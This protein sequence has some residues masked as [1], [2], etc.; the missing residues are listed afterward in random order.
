MPP[1]RGK[2]GPE[3]DCLTRAKICELHATNGWGATTI[4]KL[5]FPDI[6][7][8][9][10]QYTLTQESKRIK[11]ESLSRIGRPRKLTDEDRDHIY[12]TIQQNP[13]ILVEDLLAEV[14][15]KVKRMAIWRLT[16]EMGL[17]KWRKMQR[18]SLTPLHAEK[19]LNWAQKYQHFTSIDWARVYWSDECTV[20]RGIGQRQEWTFTRPKDQLFQHSEEGHQVQMVPARGKQIKQMFWAA[21]CGLPRRSGLIPLF[22]DPLSRRG[23]VSS[24]TIEELYRRVLP[25]LL[26]SINQNAIFQQDNAL[27]H[28]AYIVR[29]ALNELEC[30]IMEWPPYSPDLNPIENL[31]ALLKAEI[32]KGYPE[33][34]HL[35]NN[36]STLELLVKAAQEAWDT[37]DT[38]IFKHLSETMPHRV[39]DVIKYEGWHT[40]Y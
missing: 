36:A 24:R 21:F 17:R 9:T 6:P 35:P 7:R 15:Y 18:P 20:E 19:R 1:I 11:Q 37:L 2:R 33:L 28:T 32:L 40:S 8:S 27:V 4:K 39:A 30:E 38:E 13:S 29:D 14:D 22:G 31:W 25:T 16:Y 5:R 34:M 26:N 12:D 3:L 23:G 10:I